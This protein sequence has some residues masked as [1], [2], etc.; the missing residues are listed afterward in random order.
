ML[1]RHYGIDFFLQSC[2]VL[3]LPAFLLIDW[4]VE[5]MPPHLT[6]PQLSKS[7]QIDSTLIGGGRLVEGAADLNT[8]RRTTLNHSYIIRPI[9]SILASVSLGLGQS[10]SSSAAIRS[11][12]ISIRHL[13]PNKFNR[14]PSNTNYASITLFKVIHL[15]TFIPY[16][17]SFH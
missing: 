12:S 4:S 9:T 7:N 11:N 2:S 8:T 1:V 13:R 14:Q 6:S 16:I 10:D 17:L 5:I 15:N 3:P